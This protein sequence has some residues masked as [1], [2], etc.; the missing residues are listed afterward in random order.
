MTL[1]IKDWHAFG[2]QRR[3]LEEDERE[4]ELITENAYEGQLKGSLLGKV[5]ILCSCMC[6]VT[7]NMHVYQIEITFFGFFF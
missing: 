6:Q 1:V 7:Y 4:R 3:E 5:D 2:I